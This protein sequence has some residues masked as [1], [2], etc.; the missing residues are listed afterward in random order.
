MIIDNGTSGTIPAF[1]VTDLDG[2]FL[3]DEKKV[4]E[5]NIQ[6][7][8]SLKSIGVPV[9]F[10]TGRPISFVEKYVKL[11]DAPPLV[12]GGNGAIIRN[13]FTGESIFQQCFEQET[14]KRLLEFCYG[15]G[16]DT[17]AYGPD[18]NVYF[19]KESDRVRVFTEYNDSL[20][21]SSVSKVNLFPLEELMEKLDSVPLYKVLVTERVFD[22]QTQNVGEKK[23]LNRLSDFLGTL[24]DVYAVPSMADV[25]DIMSQGVSKG[26]AVKHLAEYLKVPLNKVGVV[27]DN[28]NDIP[29]FQI[30][31]KSVCMCNGNEDA[32][33]EAN[34][35]TTDTNN[36]AGFAEAIQWLREA[37]NL[38]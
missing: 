24:T 3:T 16:F 26:N 9:F 2:T 35:I 12:I 4:P 17:L 31:G 23:D 14:Q 34:W 38:E 8:K 28:Q 20:Q 1:I 32:K 15:Q 29:M 33:K 10:C 11:A 27:G 21:D 37:L 36:E 7:I 30:A 19:S 13:I 6:A 5:K 18:G 25:I 22:N